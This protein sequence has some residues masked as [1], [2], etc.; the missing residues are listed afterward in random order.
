M[1]SL[2]LCRNIFDL[3]LINFSRK[4][5]TKSTN[6]IFLMTAD[7]I[8]SHKKKSHCS[9]ALYLH[10]FSLL[11]IQRFKWWMD[12]INLKLFHGLLTTKSNLQHN[13]R[14]EGRWI[15]HSMPTCSCGTHTH[16][17]VHTDGV[18]VNL[19]VQF[20]AQGHFDM[21][22]EGVEE[23]PVIVWGINN[24]PYLLSHISF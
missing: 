10:Y 22:S 6:T 5:K 4:V 21:Q 3:G 18:A 13:L 19:L 24:P 23:Q 15:P 9:H 14:T 8:I 16:T 7:L 11:V 20:L 17:F 2:C 1:F 12:C